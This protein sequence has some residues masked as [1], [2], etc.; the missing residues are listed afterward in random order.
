M[1]GAAISSSSIN[2]ARKTTIS[3]IVIKLEFGD[4]G[5]AVL[6]GVFIE[7]FISRVDMNILRVFIRERKRCCVNKILRK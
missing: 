5:R 2:E 6:F 4:I 7:L 1:I 3:S